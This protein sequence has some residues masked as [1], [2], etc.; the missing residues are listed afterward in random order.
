MGRH[1]EFNQSI[2]DDICQELIGGKSLRKICTT[3]GFPVISTVFKWI[4]RYPEFEKQYVRARELQAE[5][6]LEEIIEISDDG[7]NDTITK[8]GKECINSEWVQRSRLRVDSRKWAMSKMAPKRFG[9]SK[10]IKGDKE[11]PLVMQGIPD[12]TP[13]QLK[14]L[15]D[16]TEEDY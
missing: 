9:E 14:A 1:C 2:A 5:Y 16:S 11:N 8:D 6:F 15:N 13:D 3:D 7:S 10:T 12:L 4:H